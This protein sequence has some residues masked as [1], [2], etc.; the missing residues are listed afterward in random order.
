MGQFWVG[1]ET[2][3]RQLSRLRSHQLA[4]PHTGYPPATWLVTT[5]HKPNNKLI[6]SQRDLK[7]SHQVYAI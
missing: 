2:L 3:L 5:S 6:M 7:K 1:V 4:G